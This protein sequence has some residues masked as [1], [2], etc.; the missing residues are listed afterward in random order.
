MKHGQSGSNRTKV[1]RAWVNI[2]TRTTNPKHESYVRYGARGI[3]VC[4]RWS[5]FN[6]FYADMGDPPS[7]NHSLGRINNDGDYAPDNCQWETKREQS[8]NRRTNRLVTINGTTR[9]LKQWTDE[10]GLNYA[11]IL[12][13]LKIGWTTDEAL[14]LVPRKK[15]DREQP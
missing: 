2:R 14:E 13:R 4:P 1:Y 11:K 7:R 5:V 15:S 12:M 3:T 6:T 10:M 9:P 8:F